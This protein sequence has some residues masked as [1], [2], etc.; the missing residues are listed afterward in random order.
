MSVEGRERETQK[1]R[2]REEEGEKWTQ[3]ILC[4]VLE[5]GQR[6][7]LAPNERADLKRGSVRLQRLLRLHLS[8]QSA[9]VAVVADARRVELRQLHSFVG[10]ALACV[11]IEGVRG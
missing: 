9:V 10:L 4:D 11:A 1:E 6:V 8:R 2:E 7:R 3:K 5:D